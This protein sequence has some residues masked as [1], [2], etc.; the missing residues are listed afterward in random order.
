MVALVPGPLAEGSSLEGVDKLLG[1]PRVAASAAE[2]RKEA[3]CAP[4]ALAPARRSRAGDR[5]GADRG[6]TMCTTADPGNPVP[7]RPPTA[8]PTPPRTRAPR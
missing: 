8:S 2:V 4:L 1:V 7:L 5:R 3:P 6:G